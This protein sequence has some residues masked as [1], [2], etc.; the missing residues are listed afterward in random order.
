[1]E[2][3]LLLCMQLDEL[4][5][6]APTMSQKEYEAKKAELEKKIEDTEWQYH[7]AQNVW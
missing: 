3:L 1:M 4:N 6:H 5:G 2:S 7:D